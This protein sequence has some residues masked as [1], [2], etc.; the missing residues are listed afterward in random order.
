MYRV[1]FIDKKSSFSRAVHGSSFHVTRFL[2]LI[3]R[4]PAMNNEY[5]I[6]T[7]ENRTIDQLSNCLYQFHISIH[8]LFSVLLLLLD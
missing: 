5:R 6:E 1:H 3:V 8:L 4:L 7:I 2:S